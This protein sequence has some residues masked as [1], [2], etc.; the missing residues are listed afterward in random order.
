MILLFRWNRPEMEYNPWQVD[1]LQAFSFLKCPECIFDTK[2]EDFFQVHT[3]EKHP[4]SFVLYGKTFIEDN[5]EESITIDDNFK[6]ETTC[7]N[8]NIENSSY[9]TFLTEKSEDSFSKE[10]SQDEGSKVF[11]DKCTVS[12]L[13]KF[14]TAKDDPLDTQELITDN[15]INAAFL[16]HTKSPLKTKIKVAIEEFSIKEEFPAINST[17]FQELTQDDDIHEKNQETSTKRSKLISSVLRR[18]KKNRK[19]PCSEC[20]S[21][22]SSKKNLRLHIKTVHEVKKPHNCTLCGTAFGLKK[23]LKNHLGFMHGDDA[24]RRPYLCSQCGSNFKEKGELKSHIDE[25]HDGKKPHVCSICGRSFTRANRLKLHISTAHERNAVSCSVCKK[26]FKAQLSLERHIKQQKCKGSPVPE[27][28]TEIIQDG[29]NF[30]QCP[31]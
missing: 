10:I 26:I 28:F 19:K 15:L 9:D 21:I 14:K 30:F 2:E 27:K 5:F 12:K 13:T 29:T 22:Y 11:Q 6:K 25:V 31:E 24:N 23:G 20:T 4:L 1:S 7:E 17:D 18:N 8:F 16:K 3:I